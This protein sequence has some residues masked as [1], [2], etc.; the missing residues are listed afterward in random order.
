MVRNGHW[1]AAQPMSMGL[2]LF[3]DLIVV[4]LFTVAAVLVTGGGR[5]SAFLGAMVGMFVAEALSRSLRGERRIP[6]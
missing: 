6:N 2:R 3:L 1:G 5:T 4:I